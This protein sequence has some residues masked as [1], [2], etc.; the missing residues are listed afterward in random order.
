MAE[1]QVLVV[2]DEPLARQR[3]IRML[4][5]I[6][7]YRVVAEAANG[8]E[9]VAQVRSQRPDLVMMDIRMPGTDGLSAARQ[10]AA[11]ANPP[12]IIFCTAYDDYAIEAFDV[13]AVGYLL[14][15]VRQQALQDCLQR[16]GQLNKIQLQALTA[17][18]AAGEARLTVRGH[19][20]TETIPLQEVRYLFA[21]Q[22]Y[23]TVV[24]Q[25]QGELRQI[26]TDQPLKELEQRFPE[27]L[28]RVHRNALIGLR[29]L[30][31]LE[32]QGDGQRVVL[33]GVDEGPLVSRRLLA[34]LRELL[35]HN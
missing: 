6:P 4:A 28:Y 19:R 12:A 8:A 1:R 9:A 3:L 5:K 17:V 7:G 31:G 11:A 20:G 10:L 21:D 25:Q 18:T 26:L 16:A 34:S 33:D 32:V 29:H 13:H 15:P 35:Q 30:R 24:Y 14:K 22:K 23:V 2:D 27:Y